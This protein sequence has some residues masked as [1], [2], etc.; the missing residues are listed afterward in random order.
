MLRIRNERKFIVLAFTSFFVWIV[1]FSFV[2]FLNAFVEISTSVAEL[3]KLLYF[4][5]LLALFY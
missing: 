2:F 3:L 4:M 1:M 5:V